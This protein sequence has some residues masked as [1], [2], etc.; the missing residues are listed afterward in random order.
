MG[1]ESSRRVPSGAACRSARARHFPSNTETLFA[2]VTVLTQ[3]TGGAKAPAGGPASPPP[4]PPAGRT[5]QEGGSQL[6]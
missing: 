2:V 4:A 3:A 1:P 5:R 6:H